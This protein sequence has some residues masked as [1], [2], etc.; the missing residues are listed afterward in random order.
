MLVRFIKYFP[1]A[2]M[3]CIIP[4]FTVSCSQCAVSCEHLRFGC[5]SSDSVKCKGAPCVQGSDAPIKTARNGKKP[6]AAFNAQHKAFLCCRFLIAF[7]PPFFLLCFMQDYHLVVFISIT[8]MSLSSS[9]V[10]SSMLSGLR[11]LVDNPTPAYPCTCVWIPVA[12]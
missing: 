10:S 8:A 1:F 5:I 7:A 2:R 12:P 4:R 6:C 9:A 3:D 11:D